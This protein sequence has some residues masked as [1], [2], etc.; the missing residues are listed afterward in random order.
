MSSIRDNR[1]VGLR[2]HDPPSVRLEDRFPVRADGETDES[3]RPGFIDFV[4]VSG[5]RQAFSYDQLIWINCLEPTRVDFHFSSHTVTVTGIRLNL[6]YDQA[7][8]R[9]LSRV[10]AQGNDPTDAPENEA[11]VAEI[12]VARV[13]GKRTELDSE[14]YPLDPE[15]EGS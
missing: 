7:L 8:I 12:A 9:R 5:H 4:R 14:D 11:F 6:V 3:P 2:P 15:D 13:E 10:E 1:T